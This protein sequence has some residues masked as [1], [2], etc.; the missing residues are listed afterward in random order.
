MRGARFLLA[1]SL[2]ALAVSASAQGLSSMEFTSDAVG[3]FSVPV[4]SMKRVTDELR[5]KTTVRQRYDFSCGSAAVAT[6]LTHHYD[7]PTTEDHALYFMY[8][9]GEQEKIKAEGF[10]MLD[11]KEYLEA[12][13]FQA[14]GFEIDKGQFTKLVS[15]S[16]PFIV[17][18]EESGYNHF[19]V[20]K[21]ASGGHVLIGDPSRGTRVMRLAEFEKLWGGRIAFLIHSH[22]KVAKFNVRAHWRVVPVFLGEGIPRESLAAVTLLRSGPNDF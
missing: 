17:L 14:D 22:Q 16:V 20:V 18:L 19:V 4:K 2:L 5:F 15:E 11:M 8:Q 6:L 21:G 10:S 12:R 3:A 7:A 13:G 1:A 9:R